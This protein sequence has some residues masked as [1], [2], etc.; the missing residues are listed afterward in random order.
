MHSVSPARATSRCDPQAMAIVAVRRAERAKTL[1]NA[2][3]QW[4]AQS[5]LHRP[6]QPHTAAGRAFVPMLRP[7]A[8]VLNSDVVSGVGGGVGSGV[9]F[10]NDSSGQHASSHAAYQ[11]FNAGLDWEKYTHRR[12]PRPSSKLTPNLP[13]PRTDGQ[14]SPRLRQLPPASQHH[15]SSPNALP[16]LDEAS[17]ETGPTRQH[18]RRSRDPS[19][20]I[21][22][23]K[24]RIRDAYSTA[25]DQHRYV[26]DSV[27]ADF[28]AMRDQLD[29]LLA[30]A[31]AFTSESFTS[32]PRAH[33]GDLSPSRVHSYFRGAHQSPRDLPSARTVLPSPVPLKGGQR[34]HAYWDPEHFSSQQAS[35]LG[36][37]QRPYE[38]LT[39]RPPVHLVQSSSP[40]Q[41]HGQAGGGGGGRPARDPAYWDAEHY[42]KPTVDPRPWAQPSPTGHY[43]SH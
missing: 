21:R 20:K 31:E 9:G 14:L 32:S 23:N 1:A 7:T 26:P 40:R 33:D 13:S 43:T 34:D 4:A 3:T 30:A 38:P 41:G 15:A 6:F 12:R 22:A 11:R 39:P 8:S 29:E 27:G 16:P 25:R 37:R 10:G 5:G 35:A 18:G 24:E 2:L 17:D 28:G 36:S 42:L 19:D